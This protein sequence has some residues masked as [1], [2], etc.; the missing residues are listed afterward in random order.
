MNWKEIKHGHILL[1]VLKLRLKQ[2][3]QNFH[4]VTK[5]METGVRSLDLNQE[6]CPHLEQSRVKGKK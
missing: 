5:S 1:V 2:R 6:G 4:E 3:Q